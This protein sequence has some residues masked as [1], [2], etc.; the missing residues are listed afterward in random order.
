[1]YKNQFKKWGWG[2]YKQPEQGNKPACQRH[3]PSQELRAL[4]NE[5]TKLLV[6]AAR[7]FSDLLEMCVAQDPE[8]SQRS[9]FEPAGLQYG[10]STQ[11]AAGVNLIHENETWSSYSGGD[12]LREGF[13]MAEHLL[14]D[15][16]LGGGID[17]ILWTPGEL[18]ALESSPA[19]DILHRYLRHL[20]DYSRQSRKLSI[21]HPIGSL[22]QAMR[23]LAQLGNDELRAFVSKGTEVLTSLTGRRVD[24]GGIDRTHVDAMSFSLFL[25]LRMGQKKLKDLRN[26]YDWSAQ[27]LVRSRKDLIEYAERDRQPGDT[28]LRLQDDLLGFQDNVDSIFDFTSAEIKEQ[29][30]ALMRTLSNL[31]VVGSFA[32]GF[33]VLSSLHSSIYAARVMELARHFFCTDQPYRA[34]SLLPNI[35]IIPRLD[36]KTF[37]HIYNGLFL[38]II[39]QLRRPQFGLV[40]QASELA[41]QQQA[42]QGVVLETDVTENFQTLAIVVP[43]PATLCSIPA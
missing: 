8:W 13:V 14:S 7:G 24:D 6:Q 19:T 43:P 23:Q 26:V 5:V 12:E 42:H 32:L 18:L 21:C 16:D 30:E 17:L 27:Q 9:R 40:S 29:S 2:K 36:L 22:I 4:E 35:M 37:L 3:S 41:N 28:L 31:N 25:E 38:F 15:L 11:I 34:L 1:M 10:L 39:D 33:R 20:E